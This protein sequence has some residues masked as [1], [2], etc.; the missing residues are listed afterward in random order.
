[1][2]VAALPRCERSRRATTIPSTLP[3][4]ERDRDGFVI[5]EG[6][7]IMILESWK[8]RNVRCPDLCGA[9]CYGMTADGIPSHHADETGS[10]AIR[11]MQKTIR[12]AGIQPEQVGYINAPRTS[13]LT[14]T[15]LRR[16]R[17]G[18]RLAPT[19]NKLAS[20]QQSQ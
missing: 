7:G 16:L 8:W 18:R 1:M 20:A 6:A 3:A 10:G 17:S 9:R 4:V 12:D 5:G 2:S 11:V 14:T 15:S 19:L 13:T